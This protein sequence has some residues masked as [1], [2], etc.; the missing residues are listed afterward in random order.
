VDSV[1]VV[2]EV[3]EEDDQVATNT[4]ED[5]VVEGMEEE[6]EEGMVG[7]EV[8]LGEDQITEEEGHQ[9]TDSTVVVILS[10]QIIIWEW[11]MVWEV[12][13]GEWTSPCMVG[14]WV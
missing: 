8:S 3:E 6:E 14:V 9:N 5:M 4:E 13:T 2:T 12:A 1:V 10:N 11:D 7:E